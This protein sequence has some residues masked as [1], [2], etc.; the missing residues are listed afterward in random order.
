MKHGELHVHALKKKKPG[1][2]PSRALLFFRLGS[3][4]P[5]K[6]TNTENPK[7]LRLLWGTMNIVHEEAMGRKDS[8]LLPTKTT[9]LLYFLISNLCS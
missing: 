3:K 8:F 2:E 9:P 1:P 6:Q 7:S 4:N 5:N